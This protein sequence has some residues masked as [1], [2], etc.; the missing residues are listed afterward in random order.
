VATQGSPQLQPLA[1]V[2]ADKVAVLAGV[3]VV[4][5]GDEEPLVE[6]E[7]TGELIHQLPHT[8]QELVH[9]RRHLLG[10]PVQVVAPGETDRQTDREKERETDRQ[11]DS[12]SEREA[13]V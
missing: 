9:D 12:V 8:L 2:V 5:D 1:L 11:T 6:L 10:V 3:G 4:V 7:G 13:P